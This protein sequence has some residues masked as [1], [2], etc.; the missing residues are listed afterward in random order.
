MIRIN[1]LKV[2]TRLILIAFAWIM[3]GCAT[4]PPDAP[5]EQ[6]TIIQS[7]SVVVIKYSPGMAV[8]NKV[9][10]LEDFVNVGCVP[11]VTTSRIFESIMRYSYSY[12]NVVPLKWSTNFPSA[13]DPFYKANPTVNL[14]RRLYYNILSAPTVIVDGTIRPVPSDSQDIKQKIN[15]RLQSI[16]PIK[17]SVKDSINNDEYIVLYSVDIKDT[18]GLSLPELIC[19][20]VVTETDIEYTTPPGSNGETK[21][22]DMMRVQF[23]YN[24][25]LIRVESTSANQLNLRKIKINSSWNKN[26]LHAIVF[27][28]NKN[29]KEILQS[30]I[31]N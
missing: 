14:D 31:S 9:V 26:K 24:N 3:V 19:H 12:S 18:I 22:Y 4:N 16:S 11:C 28:Q 6:I 23:P 30:A 2:I 15:T 20:V 7:D 25:Q 27:I 8:P 17:I 10:L 1:K 21:F 29:T 5:T 13:N